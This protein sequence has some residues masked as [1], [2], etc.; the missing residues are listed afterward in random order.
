MFLPMILAAASIAAAKPVLELD[1][2]KGVL[3]PNTVSA[4]SK[5]FKDNFDRP[6]FVRDGKEYALFCGGKNQY[7]HFTMTDKLP[8]K[9]EGPFTVTCSFKPRGGWSTPL[10][11]YRSSWSSRDGFS[12]M[13][14]GPQMHLRIGNKYIISSDKPNPLQ[15]NTRY[16]VTVSWNGKS[17]QMT[18]N[19]RLFKP[20]SNPPF[21]MP[22]GSVK[23][24]VGGYNIHTN[25][26]FEGTIR[27]VKIYNKALTLK[28]IHC[29]L[30][31]ECREQEQ[32]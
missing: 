32:K 28:E 31:K 30:E 21:V 1:Y 13:H 20:K 19:G 26:I 22:K 15:K 2:T 4:I 12:I 9:A 16:F 27:K 24:H 6:K 25:N 23:F 7:G 10:I 18:L 11:Y 29:L 14:S 3:P 17:W 8:L 5:K